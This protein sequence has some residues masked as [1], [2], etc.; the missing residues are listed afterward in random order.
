MYGKRYFFPPSFVKTTTDNQDDNT[1]A[2]GYTTVVMKKLLI[3][4]CLLFAVHCSPFTTSAHDIPPEILE[5]LT[6]NPDATEA[7]FEDW[8]SNQSLSGTYQLWQD[9]EAFES[10]N[11]PDKLVQW[12]LDNQTATDDEVLG[13][14]RSQPDFAEWESVIVK[15]LQDEVTSDDFTTNDLVLLDALDK[16]L[17][18]SSE[19]RTINWGQ[20]SVNY[21]RLG[22][23]H[24]LSGWDHVLFV[25]VL[26]LLL[27]P[28]RKILMM[29]TTFTL[30]HTLTLL[31][32]GTHILTL[33]ASIVEPIIAA[34]IVYVALK[35]AF[36]KPP[37]SPVKRGTDT[38]L[39]VIFLFGLFHGLG[40]A[41]VFAEIAPDVSRLLPSLL[42]FNV[43]VELG[44]ILILA[45]WVP[46]LYVIYK[47]KIDRY[48]VPVFASVVS[49]WASW[50]VIERIIF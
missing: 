3:A 24:I 28:W 8:L 49:V 27:P 47:Y 10:F 35:A 44:Q 14:V 37:K 43:G 36:T 30:A 5:F 29:V 39:W 20:F 50:W 21:I 9:E 34:S 31:L 40:F 26:V 19:Q 15:L 38:S 48:V 11:L 4:C 13:Y 12:L 2:P 46:I 25:M 17:T 45:V 22:V 42:F 16:Q 32:G 41:G 1:G 7:E 23:E 18:A 33:S 6:E